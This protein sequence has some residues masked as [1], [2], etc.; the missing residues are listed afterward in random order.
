MSR[1]GRRAAELC[2]ATLLAAAL[3]LG[4]E[5]SGAGVGAT[6]RGGLIAFERSAGRSPSDIW[7]MSPGGTSQHLL[8]RGCC[9]DWSPSG[10]RIAFA[11]DGIYA[12]ERD[13]TERRRLAA[14]P[15]SSDPLSDVCLGGPLRSDWCE[16]LALDW[17]PDG[18]SVAFNDG[19]GIIVAKADGSGAR[20]LTSGDDSL[21]SWSPDG[22]SLA[23]SRY[24]SGDAGSRGFDLFLV[25]ADGTGLR[26]LTRDRQYTVVPAAWSPDGR[27]IAYE[28]ESDIWIMRSNGAA[29]TNLTQTPYANVG[30]PSWSPDGT[31]VLFESSGSIHSI[32]V[33]GRLHRN[34]TRGRGRGHVDPWWSAD[35]DAIVF[36]RFTRNQFDVW[37]MGASGSDPV[38]LTS[39]R[40]PVNDRAPA[41]M[42]RG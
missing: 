42:P 30:E 7:L 22:A 31:T 23:F 6:N 13:G 19:R 9:V 27:R 41:W 14:L 32:R 26:R 17:S 40:R 10:Q 29:Q 16:S 2:I 35:G 8:A 11:S 33:D 21:P 15:R 36:S 24:V 4:G 1:F 3:A 5:R 37:R 25:D 18:R 34:L 20:R 12:I 39:T 28:L 38:R